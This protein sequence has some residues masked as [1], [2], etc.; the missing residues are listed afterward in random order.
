MENSQSK[1]K[2]STTNT[3]SPN[4]DI[5]SNIS[6][7]LTPAP[8]IINP[9]DNIDFQVP[10]E[11][12][13]AGIGDNKTAGDGA[14]GN[15]H[16]EGKSLI[17]PNSNKKIKTNNGSGTS[18]MI[19]PNVITPA[20]PKN[21]STAAIKDT[22]KQGIIG[23]DNST[24]TS[25]KTINDKSLKGN[26][27]TSPQEINANNSVSKS[28]NIPSNK[29]DQQGSSAFPWLDQISKLLGVK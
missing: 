2:L 4:S 3:P 20:N 6:L 8:D 1:D 14:A 10:E 27:K 26:N 5:T 18:E 16:S 24:I 19:K 13:K 22:G 25:N 17:T 21:N 11:N 7:I 12:L 15:S 9:S 29:T 28:S 23:T